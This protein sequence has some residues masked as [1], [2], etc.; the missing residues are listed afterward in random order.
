MKIYKLTYKQLKKLQEGGSIIVNGTT[1]TYDNNALYLPI[2][3]LPSYTLDS[4]GRNIKLFKDGEIVS[5]ALVQ[6][7]ESAERSIYT[8][9]IV[10]EGDNPKYNASYLQAKFDSIPTKVSQLT[11]DSNFTSNT[12]TI[13]GI[14][15]NGVSKGTSG[16]VD[17]GTVITAH[18]DISGKQ[19]KLTA[20]Q[21]NA[22]N[23]GIT[24]A[25]VEQYNGYNTTISDH[26]TRLTTLEG[27]P[28]LDKT[29]TVS[30]IKING[31]SKTPINGAVDLGTVITSHQDIS[32]KQDKLSTAQLNAANS[33]ITSDKVKQ[34]DGYNSTIGNHTT[35]ITTLEGKPGLDKTGTVSSIKINGTAKTPTNGVV[36]LGT[37]ITS[38]QS[39]DGKQD[40]LT[41]AQLNAVNSGIT[42]DKVKVYDGYSGT[43]TNM[44]TTINQQGNR[45]NTLEAKPGLDKVGTITSINNQT[46]DSQGNIALNIPSPVSEATVS[47]WGF[48]KNTGTYNK[49][50]G[51]IPKTDLA[52]AVQTSLT[53]ADN[54]VKKV[55]INGVEK[56]PISGVVD[57]GTVITAHQ[58][59]DGKQDKITEDNKLS[60]NLLTDTPDISSTTAELDTIIFLGNTGGGT[61]TDEQITYLKSFTQINI[62]KIKY[63]S[64][65]TTCDMIFHLIRK[66]DTTLEFIGT[67]NQIRVDNCVFTKLMIGLSGK[68]Y[69]FRNA[70]SKVVDTHGTVGVDKTLPTSLFDNFKNNY[71]LQNGIKIFDTFFWFND[72]GDYDSVLYHTAAVSS[73]QLLLTTDLGDYPDCVLNLEDGSYTFKDISKKDFVNTYGQQTIEGVKTFSHYDNT[74]PIKV[75]NW[76]GKAQDQEE[77]EI[78]SY[79]FKYSY[80]NN[81]DLS[82][83]L[84]FPE[85]GTTSGNSLTLATTDDVKG[86]YEVFKRTNMNSNSFSTDWTIKSN[87]T[88]PEG[89][90]LIMQ[91]SSGSYTQSADYMWNRSIFIWSIPTNWNSDQTS[92]RFQTETS[93]QTSNNTWGIDGAIAINFGVYAGKTSI[94]LQGRNANSTPGKVEFWIYK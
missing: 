37:V 27:K 85:K 70:S 8:S 24:S 12:G 91:I 86:E 54:A 30:S 66:T 21:L 76:S 65:S 58:S 55:K 32:G 61:L 23:S 10:G 56:S 41:T 34:Y 88:L 49:P 62:L 84:L 63:S 93:T 16:V 4:E 26:T 45:L 36:D 59:L 13:T 67:I 94:S 42:S 33:G 73:S 9:Y 89:A 83:K 28:G 51:G 14:K 29:G 60:Y 44:S 53:N 40:K 75:I 17:L 15:M 52:N 71:T 18:Q 47:G 48:T 79:G 74:A 38:H 68:N 90:T 46:P 92:I 78:F 87:T 80:K 11:N 31:T 35:R 82:E 25:K 43:L 77:L 81:G 50:S 7:A 3:G 64:S 19:D 5:T 6:Q 2:D 57:L 72:T 69:T 39:L 20:A 22:V 1:Y